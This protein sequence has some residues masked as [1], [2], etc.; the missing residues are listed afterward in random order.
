MPAAEPGRETPPACPSPEAEEKPKRLNPLKLRQLQE[1]R[2]VIEETVAK[3]EAGIAEHERSLA[4]FKS[5]EETR[6]L[7]DSLQAERTELESLLAEWEDLSRT[8]DEFGA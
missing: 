7:M 5:A 2:Q 6:R 4:V 8:I 3:L 1:R